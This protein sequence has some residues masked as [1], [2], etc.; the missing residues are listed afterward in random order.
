MLALAQ[1]AL[2]ALLCSSRTICT[3]VARIVAL[4][5]ALAS[6]LAFLFEGAAAKEER[7]LSMNDTMAAPTIKYDAEDLWDRMRFE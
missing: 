6:A 2:L 7:M 3:T 4:F 5:L 1:E